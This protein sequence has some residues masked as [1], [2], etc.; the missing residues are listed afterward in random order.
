MFCS[1]INSREDKRR[2]F[3]GVPAFLSR[4]VFSS[5]CDGDD[6]LLFSSTL[7][8]SS[9]TCFLLS[10]S[11]TLLISLN[12]SDIRVGEATEEKKEN[13]R[14]KKILHQTITERVMLARQIV[15]NFIKTDVVIAS[16]RTILAGRLSSLICVFARWQSDLSLTSTCPQDICHRNRQRISCQQVANIFHQDIP[17]RPS[18]CRQGGR[19][20]LDMNQAHTQ[21]FQ[22]LP[23]WNLT[24]CMLCILIQM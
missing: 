2:F 6:A 7:L 21:Y 12:V 20:L 14:V 11:S 19:F 23:A 16:D 17:R 4:L 3:F 9:S 24:G 5:C 15:R 1:A 18:R 10:T 13:R 22:L 8:I